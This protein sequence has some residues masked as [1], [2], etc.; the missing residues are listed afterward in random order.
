[1]SLLQLL[2]RPVD[3]TL[4]DVVSR[5]PNLGIGSRVARSS[6]LQHGDSW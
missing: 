2:L 3:R 6:W 4:I 5:L 1:M